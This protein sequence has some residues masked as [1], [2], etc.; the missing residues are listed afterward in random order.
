[1]FKYM[2]GIN[3]DNYTQ[4]IHDV[5]TCRSD[6]LNADLNLLQDKGLVIDIKKEFELFEGK[7]VIEYKNIRFDC[8]LHQKPSKN[9]YVFLNAAFP[10][11]GYAHKTHFSRWS[12]Y[13][14][15]NGNVLN[16]ADPMCQIYEGLRLGWYYGNQNINLRIYVSEIVKLIAEKLEIS[17]D[18]IIFYGS[19]GGG[20]AVIECAS[21]IEYAKAVSINPQIELCRHLYA[22]DF[23]KITHNDLLS[24][25]SRWQKNNC[26]YYLQH[27]NNSKHIIMVNLRSESD[28]MHLDYIIQA[29]GLRLRYGLN[30][31]GD[32]IIWLYDCDCEPYIGAHMLQDNH[33]CFV[34]AIQMLIENIDSQEFMK[35]KDGSFYRYINEWWYAWWKTQQS[36]R[37][38]QPDLKYLVK[39]AKALKKTALFGTGD[40]AQKLCKE[41]L[42]IQGENYYSVEAV[43]DNDRNRTGTVF[44]GIKITHPDD[45]NNWSDYFIIISTVKFIKEVQQQLTNYGLTYGEDYI[46]CTDLY[47]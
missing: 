19:S 40:E 30:F 46:A 31:F 38:R 36:W 32:L 14:F 10:D 33:Y 25:D 28:M 11:A 26:T 37:S 21:H 39:C 1:M 3:Y 13:K 15:M 29:M 44:Y 18:H 23:E 17:N 47:R 42:D 8:F 16:I 5:D 45:I 22:D 35:L 12:Y 41:L 20:A 7:A 24:E 34:F 27:N 6:M 2:N 9:L 43:F 4:F